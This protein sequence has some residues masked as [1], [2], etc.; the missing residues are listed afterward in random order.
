MT[1]RIT[2][3]T[4][5][6]FALT[7]LSLASPV[8]DF[9]DMVLKGKKLI[10]EGA[11]S[12]DEKKLLQARS[13]FERLLQNKEMQWLAEYYVGYADYRLA[14][15]H[16]IQQNTEKQVQY[17]DDG[18][19]HLN[20][21]IEKNEEFADAHGLLATLL[22]QKIGTDP[23][24]GMTLGME[25]MTAMSDALEYGKENPRV[26]MFSGLSAFYTPEQFGGSRTRGVEE[27]ERSAEL[28]AKEK[29]EDKRM[30]DWGNTDALTFLA[31]FQMQT[32]QLNSAEKNLEKA[33]KINPNSGFAKA[34]QGQL[35]RNRSQ[36]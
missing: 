5:F 15:V 27:M 30:P 35:R 29:L 1:K 10:E 12:G 22:G 16:M 13:L 28:F 25:T 24:L 20:V 14:A 31:L 19:E 4:L 11:D 8:D 6:C 34:I 7:G 36:N 23:S 18:I 26:A 32:D 2:I 17:L 33:L 21:S 9:D 3:L